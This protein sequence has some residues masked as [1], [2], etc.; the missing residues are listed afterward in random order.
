[1]ISGITALDTPRIAIRAISGTHTEPHH[2]MLKSL[3]NKTVSLR[4][5]K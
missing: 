4:L 2:I 1:M 3:L 5:Y